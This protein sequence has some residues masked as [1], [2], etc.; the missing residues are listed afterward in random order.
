MIN[1]NTSYRKRRVLFSEDN[2][3]HKAMCY[4]QE[5]KWNVELTS[6]ESKTIIDYLNSREDGKND[7][8]QFNDNPDQNITKD[9]KLNDFLRSHSK[10]FLLI[11]NVIWD[12]QLQYDAS[13]FAT[14]SDWVVQTIKLMQK[15]PNRGLIIRVHPAAIRR[16]SAT[17]EPLIDVI[18]T[19][20]PE[21][22]PDN[23]FII[24]PEEKHSTYRIAEACSASIYT[25]PKL[26]WN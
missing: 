19:S 25:E 15:I 26:V 6:E 4:E 2:T 21:G 12:A 24:S 8:Q 20:F 23:V 14:M 22:L 16:Y 5:S 7:W 13:I 1:W 17:R 10:N 11:P 18:N 9:G 3:Y